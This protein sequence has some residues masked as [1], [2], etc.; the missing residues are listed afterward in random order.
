MER[1]REHGW[2]WLVCFV[3]QFYLHPV[4]P[5]Q[6]LCTRLSYLY[7]TYW[8]KH[9]ILTVFSKHVGVACA[10]VHSHIRLGQTGRGIV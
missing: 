9:T 10:T 8:L 4:C 7:T 5:L 6:V 1:R 3:R 2:E